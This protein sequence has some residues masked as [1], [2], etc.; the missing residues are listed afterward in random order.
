MRLGRARPADIRLAPRLRR[1]DRTTR[2]NGF[3]LMHMAGNVRELTADPWR[4]NYAAAVEDSSVV[5]RGGS[6][7]DPAERLRSAAREGIARTHSDAQ[8]GFRILRDLP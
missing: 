2:R 8:T 3:R 5:V 1:T 7:A 6:Y 4:E